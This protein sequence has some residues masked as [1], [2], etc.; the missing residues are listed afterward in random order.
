MM[1]LFPIV[2]IIILGAAF[3]GAFDST[4]KL[5]DVNVLYTVQSGKYLEDSFKSFTKELEG[6]MG[7][8]FVETSNIDE[9]M[10]SVRNTKYYCYIQLTNNPEEIKVYKNERYRGVAGLVQ[11][12]M[13]VFAERYSAIAEIYKQN[14]SIVGKILSDQSMDF[15]RTESLDKKRQPSSLDYYAVSML[16]LILMYASLTGLWGVKGEQNLKTGSRIL[17]S[18]V[19]KSEY[20]LGKVLGGILVTLVQACLIILFSKFILKAYWG[21]DILTIMLLVVAQSIMAIS[22]GTGIAFLIR[23]DGAASGV[24]NS[25]IPVVVFFGGGY[26]PLENMGPGIMKL[27]VVSPVRW[28][29]DA[30]FRVIYNNDYSLVL[31]ALLVNLAVAAAFILVSAVL[32][33]KGAQI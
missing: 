10:E 23:N 13:N 14:P 22:I 27:S 29:N 25:I 28:M 24:L 30:I 7:I 32:S 12:M 17:F 19:R 21:T 1:V 8:T 15:V 26:T 31:T 33:R 9:G 20:L 11:S 4:I 5:G 18:P 3:S 16:T 6:E 2:L